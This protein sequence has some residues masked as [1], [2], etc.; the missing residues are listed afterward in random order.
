M[1]YT[2]YIENGNVELNEMFG[3]GK[4]FGSLMC[5]MGLCINTYSKPKTISHF[6]INEERQPRVLNLKVLDKLIDEVGT[7]I[8]PHIQTLKKSLN[9]TQ[10]SNRKSSLSKQTKNKTSKRKT[11]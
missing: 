6:R 9:F 5:P 7:Q 3:G 8:E 1:E 2:N 10:K 11:M 4:K